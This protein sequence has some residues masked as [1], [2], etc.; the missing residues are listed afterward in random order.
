MSANHVR[1]TFLFTTTDG[2]I[3]FQHKRLELVSFQGNLFGKRTPGPRIHSDTIVLE[4]AKESWYLLKK[5]FSQSCDYSPTFP[6]STYLFL[7][8]APVAYGSSRARGRTG[9]A[10]EAYAA[11]CSN[12]RSLNHWARPGIE[13]VSS[14]R[15]HWVLNPLNH[16]KNS[17]SSKCIAYILH[18]NL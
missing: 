12:T 14:R 11:S 16:Y 9:V 5:S 4:L 8:A 6:S 17:F 3:K 7:V 2:K 1:N 15:Q 18:V 13:P 10:A